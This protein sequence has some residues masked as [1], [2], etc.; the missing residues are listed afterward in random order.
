GGLVW[1]ALP[2]SA[3]AHATAVRATVAR[4]G[5][6]ATLM[7]APD[8]VRAVVPVFHPQ[9]PAL[10]QL[11]ARVKH[12]FDPRRILNPGRMATGL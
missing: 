1:L 8:P 4:H 5:G 2:A 11:S 3:D 12:A 9:D 7:R 10:A 6:H